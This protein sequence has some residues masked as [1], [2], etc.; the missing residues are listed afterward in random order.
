MKKRRKE[1]DVGAQ[2]LRSTLSGHLGP[3]FVQVKRLYL[4]EHHIG[5]SFFLVRRRCVPVWSSCATPAGTSNEL[6]VQNEWEENTHTH[7]GGKKK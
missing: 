7:K 4:S 5:F 2:H 1:M 3:D 6:D